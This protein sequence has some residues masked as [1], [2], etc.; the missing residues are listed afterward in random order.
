MAQLENDTKH[1]HGR[2]TLGAERRENEAGTSQTGR[3]MGTF[4]LK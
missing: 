2:A 3:L 1:E 4:F